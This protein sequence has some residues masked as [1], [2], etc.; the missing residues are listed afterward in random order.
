MNFVIMIVESATTESVSNHQ[1][2]HTITS[3]D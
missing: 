2:I 3:R 1:L